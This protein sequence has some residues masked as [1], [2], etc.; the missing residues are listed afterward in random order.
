MVW[1]Y[2]PEEAS[3]SPAM[4]ALVASFPEGSSMRFTV[5]F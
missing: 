4:S 1:S 5:R 3:T 2:E